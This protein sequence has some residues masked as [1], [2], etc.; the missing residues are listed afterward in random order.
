MPSE[1]RS[2]ELLELGSV[3]G[4]FGVRG[5]VRLFLHN[6]DASLLWD[7]LSDVIL[8]GPDGTRR[9][10]EITVRT[11]AGR[12]VLGRISGVHT[13]ADAAALKDWAIAIPMGDLPP[14]APGEYWVWQ[15]EGLPVEVDGDVVGRVTDVHST[16]AGEVFVVRTGE[17]VLFIPSTREFVESLDLEAGVLRLWP[18]VLGEP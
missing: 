7:G 14:L 4:V 10:A 6:R 12:R 15:V 13:P 5:E 1:P 8:V 2:S 11:G 17:D 9:P 3:T 18:K 16:P